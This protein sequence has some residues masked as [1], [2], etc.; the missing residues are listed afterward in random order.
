MDWLQAF[1][2]RDLG[3]VLAIPAA[4]ADNMLCV[5]FMGATVLT[6]SGLL[7]GCMGSKTYYVDERFTAQ[8]QER[9][10]DAAVMWEAATGG[11]LH[12]DLVFD[13]R[14]DVTETEQNAIVKVG[15]RAAFN[16]FPAMVSDARAA[17]YHPGS[18]L[19]S[20]LI[21]VITDRIEGDMLRPAIAHEMGHS[22]GLQHV[23]EEQALMHEDLNDDVT[24]CVTSVD[25][26][27]ARRY[28]EFAA[29]RPCA[30]RWPEIDVPQ[31]DEN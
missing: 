7:A 2:K 14:V 31:S 1:A 11:V 5:R 10:K 24:K 6:I 27:E 16:R 8:E 22:F 21:V 20:S 4:D 28:F 29:E 18:T 15:A 26:R 17:F 19:E 9:I 25:L 3:G 13:K 23:R 30:K 12:F